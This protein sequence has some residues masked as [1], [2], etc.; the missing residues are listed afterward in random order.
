MT[1]V[2][3]TSEEVQR[4]IEALST[5]LTKN[6]ACDDVHQLKKTVALIMKLDETRAV[7]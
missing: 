7:S 2:E 3:L 4:I 1:K 6:R 5:V